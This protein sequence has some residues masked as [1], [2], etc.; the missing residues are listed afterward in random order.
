[1]KFAVRMT[2]SRILS[3][4][5]AALIPAL[6][7]AYGFQ[8]RRY[9]ELAKEIRELELKQEELIEQNKKLVGDISLLS[10]TDRVE[11][12]AAEDLGM[13][14]AAKDDIVRVEMTGAKK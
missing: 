12:I 8:T 2:V 9:A 7:I 14:K 4:C 5:A 3:C 10:R 1:M 13:S 6:L 11:R